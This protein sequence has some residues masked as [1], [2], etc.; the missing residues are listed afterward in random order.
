MYGPLV[1][2]ALLTRGEKEEAE[3][4]LVTSVVQIPHPHLIRFRI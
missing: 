4:P 1:P 3:K 2:E